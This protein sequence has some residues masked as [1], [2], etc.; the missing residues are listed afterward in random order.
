MT[1]INDDLSYEVKLL[2]WK[3]ALLQYRWELG[4]LREKFQKF[5]EFESN[6]FKLVKNSYERPIK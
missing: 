5:R 6:H 2:S 1:I 3:V 4:K